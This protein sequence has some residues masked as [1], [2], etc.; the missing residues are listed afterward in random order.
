MHAERARYYPSIGRPSIDPVLMI[1]ILTRL[2]VRHPL[3]TAAVPRRAGEPG[4]RWFCG[5]A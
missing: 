1:R 3:G 5:R 4:L 2:R